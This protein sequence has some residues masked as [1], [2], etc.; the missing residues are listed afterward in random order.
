[1]EMLYLSCLAGRMAEASRRYSLYFGLIFGILSLTIMLT[2]CRPAPSIL[3][4]LCACTACCIRVA[5]A[6]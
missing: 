4:R 3:K 6:R 2:Q 1:M 5:L